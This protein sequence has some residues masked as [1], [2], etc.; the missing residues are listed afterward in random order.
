[1]ITIA[2]PSRPRLGSCILVAILTAH[3]GCM[4][5]TPPIPAEPG[6]PPSRG[7]Y[8]GDG[9]C[10]TR[11]TTAGQSSGIVDESTVVVVIGD[12]DVP[13]VGVSD[14]EP[15]F[16]ID[17]DAGG[18]DGVWTVDEVVTD[19]N[20]VTVASTGLITVDSDSGASR[21]LS[22]TRTETYSQSEPD[23][24]RYSL[25]ANG[26]SSIDVDCVWNL[27]LR[28]ENVL[29][30][31][32]TTDLRIGDLQVS[33]WVADDAESRTQGLMLVTEDQMAPTAEGVE[34]GMLFVFETDIFSGFWMKDTII[35]LDI[36]FIASDGTIVGA[37]TMTPLDLQSTAPPAPYRYA[38]ELRAGVLSQSGVSAGDRV[39]IPNSILK[40]FE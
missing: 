12:G 34:R 33:A 11:Q 21:E 28:E 6:S 13:R 25:Q 10:T 38:L 20:G 32:E 37:F 9:N 27:R 4:D 3:V 16:V 24:L 7:I 29:S 17:S 2:L 35:G 14:V 40:R 23:R 5:Q 8:L 36:A 31:I 22:S 26:D 18:L 1:M 19:E 39:D 15:G 30:N